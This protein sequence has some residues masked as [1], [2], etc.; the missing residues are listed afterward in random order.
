MTPER[1]KPTVKPHLA[2]YVLIGFFT[3]APLWVTWLVFD[4][5]LG[6]LASAGTP[7]LRAATA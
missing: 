6:M 3:I 7:L 1:E 5:L 2:R 4:F